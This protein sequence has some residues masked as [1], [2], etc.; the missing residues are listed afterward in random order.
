MARFAAVWNLPLWFSALLLLTYLLTYYWHGDFSQAVTLSEN[1]PRPGQIH[2]SFSDPQNLILGH[3]STLRCSI[4][5]SSEILSLTRGGGIFSKGEGIFQINSEDYAKS[6][7]ISTDAVAKL[8]KRNKHQKAMIEVS[9][10]IQIVPKRSSLI[11]RL[12]LK[13]IHP[14]IFFHRGEKS[15]WKQISRKKYETFQIFNRKIDFPSKIFTWEN[16]FFYWKFGNFQIFSRD[17]FSK[18]FFS[19]MKKYFSTGF[20]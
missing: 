17:F 2:P 8:G 6:T 3:F 11:R 5:F 13:K 18:W 12:T 20:F 7:M 16:R 15:F 1:R 14:N 19:T 10:T 9:A 4:F